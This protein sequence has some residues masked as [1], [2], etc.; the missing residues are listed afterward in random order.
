MEPQRSKLA[1]DLIHKVLAGKSPTLSQFARSL[2]LQL[3][4]CFRLEM[5]LGD[6]KGAFLEADVREKAFANPELPRGE[7][8]GSLRALSCRYLA[9]S[10]VQ[11]MPLMHGMLNL[12]RQREQ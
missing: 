10:T 1:P 9:T 5:K 2:I 6:I 3:L 7:C 12:T 4:V 8:Q 11:M